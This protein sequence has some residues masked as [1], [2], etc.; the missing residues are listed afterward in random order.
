MHCLIDMTQRSSSWVTS[1][2]T[3]YDVIRIM[4]RCRDEISHLF[5]SGRKW[6]VSLSVIFVVDNDQVSLFIGA[7]L[8]IDQFWRENSKFEFTSRR[9]R[10][11]WKTCWGVFDEFSASSTIDSLLIIK[12]PLGVSSSCFHKKTLCNGYNGFS[13]QN[14]PLVQIWNSKFRCPKV[15]CIS[16][17][18]DSS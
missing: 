8:K 18:S 10:M 2:F 16:N 5:T 13:R 12:V 3:Y 6:E 15:R 14:S 4:M 1:S 9:A 11:T 7:D 17:A